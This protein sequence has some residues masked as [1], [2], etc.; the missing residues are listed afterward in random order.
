QTDEI[1]G[2]VLE[3]VSFDR[4]RPVGRAITALVRRNHPNPGIAQRLDL[5]A[6]G[7]C[8]LRPAVAENDGRF[9]GLRAGLIKAHPNPV[10]LGKLQRRHLYHCFYSSA[11]APS[12]SVSGGAKAASSAATSPGS[13][14]QRT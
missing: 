10:G 11:A 3:V 4:F 13:M 14:S 2:Q 5:V 12:T 7:K 1:A 9:V 6:P 8:D